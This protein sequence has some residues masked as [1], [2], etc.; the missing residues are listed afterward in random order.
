MRSAPKVEISDMPPP[1]RSQRGSGRRRGGSWKVAYAD[2]VTAMMALFIVLW[3]MNASQQVQHAVSS[4]FRNPKG[5]GKVLGEA[6]GGLGR[7]PGNVAI[8]RDNVQQLKE[9]LEQAISSLPEFQKLKKQV[10]ISIT[11]EGLRV[12]LLETERGLFFESGR[13]E[14]SSSGV[15][16][17]GVLARELARLK[18]DMV[19]EGHTD[20][21]PY[22]Y[23][24]V[25]GYTNWELSVDRANSARRCM[26]DSG[27][28][29]EQVVQIRGFADKRPLNSADPYDNRNR[30]VSVVVQYS[31]EAAPA[32]QKTSPAGTRAPH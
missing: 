20:A 12:E 31:G 27:L 23:S 26:Q 22:R 6:E 14:P 16:V 29:L 32:A 10:Q 25:T 3:M 7:G 5:H 4:Y 13:P 2:F 9:K 28:R 24:A 18:N 17:L 1:R 21:R 19:I 11:P 30:R 8:N 15:Q